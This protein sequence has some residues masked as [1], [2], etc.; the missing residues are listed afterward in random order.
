MKKEK[1]KRL[2]CGVNANIIKESIYYMVA[3]VTMKFENFTKTDLVILTREG[4]S[5][6]VSSSV[7]TYK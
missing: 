1:G 4:D 2:D 7:N 5:W 6:K 3:K